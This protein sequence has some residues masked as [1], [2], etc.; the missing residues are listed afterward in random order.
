MQNLFFK[1]KKINLT[2]QTYIVGDIHGHFDK[3]K[4]NM[5]EYGVTDND[6]LIVNGDFI[7]KGKQ[8]IEVIN[9]LLERKNTILLFGNHE[10]GF[11]NIMIHIEVNQLHI[12]KKK[13]TD[14][15]VYNQFREGMFAKWMDDFSFEELFKLRTKL[16]KH[17]SSSL[18]INIPK[19][20]KKMG[21][22]HAAVYDYDW[23]NIDNVDFNVWNFSYF[24]DIP[25]K[26][27]KFIKGIDFV[28]FGHVPV[29]QAGMNNN[30]IY[31][32]TGSYNRYKNDLTFFDVNKFFNLK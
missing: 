29:E 2:Q 25:K 6:L 17:C 15:D 1:P 27:H 11:I 16:F 10:Y 12:K 9:Y 18:E 7:N 4:K 20:N 24:N 30:S 5:K 3:F 31:I 13:R 8:T 28:V 22:V 23:K 14:I 32:D 19:I 26:E 21:V